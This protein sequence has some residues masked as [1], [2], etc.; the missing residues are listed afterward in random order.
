ML[1]GPSIP[2]LKQESCAAARPQESRLVDVVGDVQEGIQ[3]CLGFDLLFC[4]ELGIG[5][6]DLLAASPRINMVIHPR[7]VARTRT[8]RLGG[9]SGLRRLDC[10]MLLE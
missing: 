10:G 6:L 1:L 9:G 7:N 5:S 8:D 4:G 3:S 2:D